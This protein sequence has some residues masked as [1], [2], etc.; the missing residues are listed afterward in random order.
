MMIV[1]VIRAGL[2]KGPVEGYEA[3]SQ[4]YTMLC[5]VYRVSLLFVIFVCH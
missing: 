4:V 2:E 5:V 3:E 1:Q